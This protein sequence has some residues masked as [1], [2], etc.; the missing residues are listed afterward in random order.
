MV[1]K[2]ITDKK[3]KEPVFKE[4]K[5]LIAEAYEMSSYVPPKNVEATSVV[6]VLSNLETYVSEPPLKELS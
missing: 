3:I 2:E 4:K 6:R 5:I 1:T